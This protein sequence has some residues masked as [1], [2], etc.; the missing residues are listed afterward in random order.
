MG[1]STLRRVVGRD[2]PFSVSVPQPAT[3]EVLPE[4]GSEPE[5]ARVAYPTVELVGTLVASFQMAT[6]LLR[7]DSEKL[8]CTLIDDTL[9][10]VPPELRF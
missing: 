6:S 7:V 2:A 4:A 8:G 9:T 3:V 1:T 5:A 10:R